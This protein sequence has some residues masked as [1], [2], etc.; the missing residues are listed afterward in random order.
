MASVN[1]ND[2]AG[3]QD[4][5][6]REVRH[7]NKSV[8]T[9][10]KVEML[11]HPDRYFPPYFY[12]PRKQI[13]FVELDVFWRLQRDNNRLPLRAFRGRDELRLGRSKHRL[14]TAKVAQV[15]AKVRED[16][17]PMRVVNRSKRVQLEEAG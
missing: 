6:H 4:G 13:C 14:I 12:E 17:R 7:A 1:L 3:P 2:G 16:A 11:Q 5:K 8:F 9:L 15:Q 10:T